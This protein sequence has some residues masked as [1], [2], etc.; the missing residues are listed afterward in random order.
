[1]TAGKLREDVLRIF[2]ARGGME[3]L[4]YLGSTR[5]ASK[6]SLCKEL[7]P[8]PPTLARTLDALQAWGLVTSTSLDQFPFSRAY[9][10]T[11]LGRALVTSPIEKW[12]ERVRASGQNE[13]GC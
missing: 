13:G 2:R 4:F 12:P 3:I 1:M 5:A 9:S 11:P 10:L 7:G 6:R 8:S